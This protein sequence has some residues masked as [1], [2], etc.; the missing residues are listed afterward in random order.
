MKD[1]VT[2]KKGKYV[3]WVENEGDLLVTNLLVDSK[4]YRFHGE[5]KE[6]V[7]KLLET[8]Q[9]DDFKAEELQQLVKLGVLLPQSV[10]EDDLL[11][12]QYYESVF[13]NDELFLCIYPTMACNFR[14]Q[15]CFEEH[16]ASY[17]TPEVK[18][19]ILNYLRKNVRY[20]RSLYI[21]W[22][23]GEPLLDREFLVDFVQ[24][25][26]LICQKER[27]PLL[28][29][30]TTNGYNLDVDT[31]TKLVK[32]NVLYY[33]ITVDGT[34]TLHNKLRPHVT[35]KETFDT[36]MNNL[37]AISK[38]KYR[39]FHIA[40]RV[41]VSMDFL[42]VADEYMEMMSKYF[43]GDSRFSFLWH[44]IRDWGGMDEEK[45]KIVTL[46]KIN[47]V[48]HVI[49][50]AQEYGLKTYMPKPQFK[51]FLCT[52][53]KKNSFLVNVDGTL[54]KCTLCVDDVKDKEEEAKEYNRV[55]YINEKG[56]MILDQVKNSKWIMRTNLSEE[57]RECPILP[58][59]LES[60]CPFARKIIGGPMKCY[61]NKNLYQKILLEHADEAELVELKDL[62][63]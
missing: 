52:A 13:G 36:I 23:G 17:M 57:C 37:I 2:Y 55:G 27:V 6:K 26:K 54:S 41:N 61:N 29:N 19:N 22:F 38:T 59:C 40:I 18:Q 33:Q 39:F 50:K 28:S 9:M 11:D 24:E 60:V 43:A 35:G 21:S 42:D 7:K 45:K 20:F 44:E 46:G 1:I 49:A 56:E 3:N 4:M 31:F 58:V 16:P 14:C 34:S 5:D 62:E 51:D 32:S 25:I 12:A 8:S 53:C 48:D 63:V 30:I 47:I 15:Y 10:N